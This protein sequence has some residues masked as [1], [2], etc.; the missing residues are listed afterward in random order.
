MACKQCIPASYCHQLIGGIWQLSQHSSQHAGEKRL[1]SSPTGSRHLC[2]AAARTRPSMRNGMGHD[3]MAHHSC[4][5]RVIDALT[6]SMYACMKR[7]HVPSQTGAAS[8]WCHSECFMQG[9]SKL[10]GTE[11]QIVH[12]LDR[13][14]HPMVMVILNL[15]LRCHLRDCRL[16]PVHRM[17]WPAVSQV[18]PEHEI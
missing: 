15:V 10:P 12:Q 18:A 8:N 11:C 4:W 13:P 7:N 16:L 9:N 5:H 17:Y 6:A 1:H 14:S 2:T 3:M